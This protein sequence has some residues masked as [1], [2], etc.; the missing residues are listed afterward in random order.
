MHLTAQAQGGLM[1]TPSDLAKLLIELIQAYRGSSRR[2]LTREMAQAMF[3]AEVEL[4]PRLFGTPMSDA[5]GM[6]VKGQGSSLTILHPGNNFPGS[7]CWLIGF[8][9]R[10]QGAIVMLNG[11]N[12][13]LLAFEV[14]FALGHVYGWPPLKGN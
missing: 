7:I 5:L 3:H 14:L 9:E 8:P 6:F 2:L 4:D 10:G 1:S 13:E 12:G 11:D